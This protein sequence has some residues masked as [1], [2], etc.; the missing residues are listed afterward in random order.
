MDGWMYGSSFF[1]V[2]EE[3]EFG[4]VLVWYGMVYCVEIFLSFNK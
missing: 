4:M 1:E 3:V 2:K